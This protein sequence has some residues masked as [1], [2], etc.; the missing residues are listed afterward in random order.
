MKE[1][2][3][4]HRLDE[5]ANATIGLGFNRENITLDSLD[6]IINPTVDSSIIL[7]T[8]VNNLYIVPSSVRLSKLEEV[9]VT[10][11]NKNEF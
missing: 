6:F 4:N 8:D 1:K 5:Q 2:G 9:L 3:I 10:T 11:T 7:K